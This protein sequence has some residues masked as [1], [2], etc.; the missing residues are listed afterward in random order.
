MAQDDDN[1]VEVEIT[2]AP[3][4]DLERFDVL[5]DG[6]IDNTVEDAELDEFRDMILDA[7]RTDGKD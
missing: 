6:F 7:R 3:G 2:L 4:V 5:F 1:M